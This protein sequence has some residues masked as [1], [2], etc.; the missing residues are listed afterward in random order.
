MGRVWAV[1]VGA[2]MSEMSLVGCNQGQLGVSTTAVANDRAK[3]LAAWSASAP[4]VLTAFP[5][6]RVV[7][8]A[9]VPTICRLDSLS[10]AVC[11]GRSLGARYV[12]LYKADLSTAPA[13]QRAV[14]QAR[15]QESCP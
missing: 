15:A 10:A 12:E 5:A 2:P 13:I 6:S 11:A 9:P 14:R 3:Y 7:V 4:A 8:S 1:S